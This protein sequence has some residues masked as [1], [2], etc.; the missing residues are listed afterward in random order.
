MSKAA[1]PASQSRRWVH[2]SRSCQGA[3][4][5]AMFNLA[6]DRLFPLRCTRTAIN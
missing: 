4:E 3:H 6:I 1:K 2:Y 5:L